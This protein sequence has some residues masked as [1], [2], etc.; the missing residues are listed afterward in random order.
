MKSQIRFKVIVVVVGALSCLSTSLLFAQTPKVEIET[1]DLEEW[2]RPNSSWGNTNYENGQLFMSS[3]EFKYY[4][5][6]VAT[7]ENITIGAKARVTLKNVAA[8]D[9]SLG[10]GLIFHSDTTPLQQGYAFLINTMSQQYS[11]VRHVPNDE[12]TV[13]PWTVSS[14]IKT[15]TEENTLE[16][17]DTGTRTDLFINGNYVDSVTN[18]FAF[19]NGVVGLYSGD[20]VKIA[21][22]RLT[23]VRSKRADKNTDR[24][25][26]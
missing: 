18:E 11:V 17:R 4:Y 2:V 14:A 3:K 9:S 8:A 25:D 12:L 7:E 24:T 19:K 5:V 20:Q 22:S 16:I 23:L 15:L 10:Y 6:L 1:L 26:H 13:I 21:F